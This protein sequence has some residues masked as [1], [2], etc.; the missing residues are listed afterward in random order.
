MQINDTLSRTIASPVKRRSFVVV[1]SVEKRG[2]A[3]PCLD[4]VVDYGAALERE[5]SIVKEEH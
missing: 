4:D 5:G 2:T 1:R 3:R